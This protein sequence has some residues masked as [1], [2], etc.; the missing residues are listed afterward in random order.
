[1]AEVEHQGVV[2]DLGEELRWHARGA[3]SSSR[4]DVI[5]DAHIDSQDPRGIDVAMMHQTTVK[6][7]RFE[8]LMPADKLRCAASYP[9]SF[10]LPRTSISCGVSAWQSRRSG[11]HTARDDRPGSRLRFAYGRL[12]A[13]VGHRCRERSDPAGGDG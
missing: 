4:H 8:A 3:A 6:V 2:R 13:A 1:M 5:C 7:D 11:P 10:A 12:V 9:G